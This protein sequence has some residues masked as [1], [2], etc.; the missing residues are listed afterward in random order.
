MGGLGAAIRIRLAMLLLLSALFSSVAAASPQATS[1]E[2]LLEL[3]RENRP[4]VMVPRQLFE[5]LGWELP[6]G[7]RRVAELAASAPGGAF[8]PRR[9]ENLP[10]RKLGYQARWHRLRFSH[11]GLEWDITGLHLVPNEPITGLPTLALI[12][13]GSANW[14]EFFVDPLNNPGL[15]QYVAQ[16]IP[17][18]LITIP[19]NYRPR[20]W[21]EPNDRRKPAYLLDRDLSENETRARNAIFTFELIADGVRRLIEKVTVGPVL[22]VGHSTAGEIQ[23]LLKEKLRTRLNDLSLGWGTGGP[24]ALRR[25]WEEETGSRSRQRSRAGALLSISALRIR[26][27]REYAEE[28]VGPLNPLP[29][30]NKREVAE[31][32]F[33]KEGWR[34]PHFKQVI[35]D[36]EHGG[37]IEHRGEMEKQI[38]KVLAK[39]RLPTDADE[40]V[41]DL[42]STMRPGCEGYRRMLWTVAG[43]DSRHWNTN[44]KRARELFIAN[45]FRRCNPAA[46]IRVVVYHLPMTHY[47]HIEM[48]RQLAGGLLAA[49]KSLYQR[50]VG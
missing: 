46:R 48:P 36:L 10:P 29:G 28:Y 26:H 5:E 35:Q 42:F 40:V 37:E 2:K 43:G 38:R 1:E 20:G 3:I 30:R 12:H 31:N 39:A 8:D 9:L 15:G 45:E 47:G 21:R 25:K 50:T 13:G 18:L 22:I 4:Y 14:Y 6:D 27:P 34:R 44:P 7:G 19:G 41:A 23:F 17:V 24:A 33:E 16:K 11:Y 32:W 49:I